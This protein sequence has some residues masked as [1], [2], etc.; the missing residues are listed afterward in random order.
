MSRVRES[1]ATPPTIPQ[2]LTLKLF[3]ERL[4]EKNA[5]LLSGFVIGIDNGE[6]SLEIDT[7]E[8]L[9]AAEEWIQTE[10]DEWCDNEE[11][12]KTLHLRLVSA[13]FVW[14][15]L[16]ELYVEDIDAQESGGKETP[17]DTLE[18]AQKVARLSLEIIRTVQSIWGL[19]HGK[20]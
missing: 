12:S 6:L 16:D 9:E 20:A 14:M 10:V 1:S 8:E 4:A 19:K 2:K 15:L 11:P 5:E 3:A 7:E 13:V 17:A 18:K